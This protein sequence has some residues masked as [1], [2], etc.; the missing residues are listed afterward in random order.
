M[1]EQ[2]FQRLTL[3]R[4]EDAEPIVYYFSPSKSEEICPIVLLCG[5]SDCKGSIQSVLYMLKHPGLKPIMDLP[6]GKIAIE[7]WGVD[8]DQISEEEFW[9]HYTITQRLNDHLKV[10]ED[11]ERNPPIGW[12]GNIILIGGSE[13]GALVTE[14]STRCPNVL[15]TINLVGA[16]DLPWAEQFW[17]YFENLKEQSF[18]FRLYD[19]LPRWLPFSFDVPASR[20]KYDALLEK[21]KE[22]PSPNL[23]M[24]GMSY[25]YHADALLKAPTDYNKIYAPFLVVTGTNDSIIESSDQ[26]VQKALNAGAP[27]NYFRVEGM[28][29]D[30][31]NRP[32]IIEEAV[33]WLTVVYRRKT[34]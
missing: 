27:V 24:G 18:W 9:N 8:G 12:D 32:E 33:E 15:A 28:D 30:V 2:H 17:S 26:F 10:I 31:K 3:E 13:G 29:H 6:L 21:I 23:W 19:T 11:L 1:Y 34:E 5:G 20:E 25:F 16:G 22:N 7:K 14:L 4:S